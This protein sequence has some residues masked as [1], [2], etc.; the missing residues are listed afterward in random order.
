MRTPYRVRSRVLFVQT[1]GIFTPGIAAVVDAVA[2]VGFDVLAQV[3][4]LG[5]V[6]AAA[7]VCLG[8]VDTCTVHRAQDVAYSI[9]QR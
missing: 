8:C 5:P 2:A 3:M 1:L 9:Y 7:A 4:A 6:V